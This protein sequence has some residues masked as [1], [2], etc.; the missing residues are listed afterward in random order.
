MKRK[1][2]GASASGPRGRSTA[3]DGLDAAAV[4]R[5]AS[6]GFTVLVLGGLLT[7]VVA[8]VVP[9]LTQ[10]WILLV[11][12]GAFALAGAK[13]RATERPW[14]HGAAAAVGSLTL[15]IPLWLLARGDSSP[16]QMLLTLVLALVVGGLSGAVPG[17]WAATAGTRP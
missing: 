10:S 6:R 16:I 1:T 12:V 11:A 14:L 3:S 8:A 4:V 15:L 2:A 7:P 13:A 5:G 9:A 17:R